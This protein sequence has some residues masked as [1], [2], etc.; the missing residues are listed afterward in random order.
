MDVRD[1]VSLLAPARERLAGGGPWVDLG[2]GAGT[3]TRALAEL[4]PPGSAIE[5]V[6]RDAAAL[7]RIPREHHGLSITT[8]H[9]DVE[10][11]ALPW[12]DLRGVMLANVMHY[13]RDAAA[14]LGR[15][16]AVVRPGGH[17]VVVEYDTDDP[18]VPWVPHPVSRASLARVASSAGF[19]AVEPLGERPSRF[20]GRTMYGALLSAGT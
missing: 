17:V 6:D 9:F 16:R 3:F 14:L 19:V 20:G 7:R 5:A 4:L 10:R 2:C 11:E 13:T 18:Q 8:R 12:V 15:V 1:A